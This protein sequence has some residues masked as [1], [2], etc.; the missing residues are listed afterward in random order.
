[1]ASEIYH[2]Q[3]YDF[4]IIDDCGFESE[5]VSLYNSLDPRYIYLFKLFRKDTSYKGDSRNYINFEKLKNFQSPEIE[6]E[7]LRIGPKYIEKY[8]GDI[9][10]GYIENN[11][12][13]A[14]AVKEIIRYVNG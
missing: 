6:D 14:S 12:D 1:M 8:R 13:L 2:S 3:P 7:S 9:N 10:I 11:D 5:L 4:I